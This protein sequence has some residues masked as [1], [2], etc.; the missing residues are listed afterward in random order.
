MV[1][2][3]ITSG[4][5]YRGK[6]LEGPFH[7]SVFPSVSCYISRGGL[8]ITAEKLLSLPLLVHLSSSFIVGF[9]WKMTFFSKS[10]LTYYFPTA[11][12]NMNVQLKDITVTARDGR[13]SHLDQVYIRGSH[14]RFFIVP[15]MLRYVSDSLFYSLFCCSSRRRLHAGCAISVPVYPIVQELIFS[16]L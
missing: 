12:D 6:L 8:S 4:Q 7:S 1:T 16:K 5:V 15:D 10:M 3:E 14:V 2:L 9:S 11:E 13:V